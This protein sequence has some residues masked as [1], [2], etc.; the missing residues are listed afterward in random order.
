MNIVILGAGRIGQF[1]ARSLS[2]D[3]HNVTLVDTSRER[4]DEASQ[5]MD[6]ATRR[7]EAT[8]YALLKELIREC[9]DLLLALTDNDEVNLVASTLARSLNTMQTGASRHLRIIARLHNT[10]YLNYESFDIA[11]LFHIDHIV[12][13]DL[14]VA[15][16]ILT[17]ALNY[18]LYSES[19]FHGGALLRTVTLPQNWKYAGKTL[20]ELRTIDNRLIAIIIRR[21]EQ[22]HDTLI[23]PHGHDT[24]LAGDEVTFVGDSHL[25]VELKELLGQ[26]AELPESCLIFGGD[27]TGV[28]LA[29]EIAKKGLRVRIADPEKSRCLEI[30]RALSS[31]RVLHAT[32]SDWDFFKSEKITQADVFI[33]CTSSEER[34]LQLSLFAKELGC[35]KVISTFSE[36]ETSHLAEK[37]GIYHIVSP[38]IVTCDRILT[39]ARQEK[40]T[41]VLSLYDER[42]EILAVKVSERSPLI[43]IPLASLGPRLPSE[44]LI[45]VIYSRGKLNI[46]SGSDI[47]SAKDEAIVV[48]HP[49][50]RKYLEEIF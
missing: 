42:A 16:Q 31:V 38:R 12:I 19:F 44:I 23:F 20:A 17:V 10:H 36:E 5:K 8:D 14:L 40:L 7:G 33:A 2:Q 9:P 22:G 46:A 26:D 43:G 35:K 15:S 25:V 32:G 4:L 34:N 11:S 39:L 30:A 18:G 24:L 28:H 47:L 6:V 45:A 50:H 29:E 1:V 49:K 48:C 21:K 37:L 3:G 13:P 41:S 27:L